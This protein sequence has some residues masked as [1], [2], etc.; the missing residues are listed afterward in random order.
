LRFLLF[1]Q[2][3]GLDFVFL[4]LLLLAFDGGDGDGVFFI[5]SSP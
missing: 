3:L 5:L 4:C 1:K 2:I